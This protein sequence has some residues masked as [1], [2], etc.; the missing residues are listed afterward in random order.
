VKWIFVLVLAL[1]S[2][3]WFLRKREGEV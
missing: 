3:E 1:L 2:L